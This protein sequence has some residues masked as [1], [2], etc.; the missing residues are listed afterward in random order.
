MVILIFL[1]IIYIL[2]V[3][4][5]A[6]SPKEPE[7][8]KKR[9]LRCIAGGYHKLDIPRQLQ[10][11]AVRRWARRLAVSL[12]DENIIANNLGFVKYQF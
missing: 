9:V 5:V 7:K 4:G 1:Q 11:R 10:G 8:G 6:I 3:F 12:T 2:S